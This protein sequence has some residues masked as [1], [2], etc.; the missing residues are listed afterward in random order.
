MRVTV[1]KWREGGGGVEGPGDVCVCGGGG[2]GWE[3]VQLP[4]SLMDEAVLKSA[5]PGL[6]GMAR[7]HNVGFSTI[8]E[9]NTSV[10]ILNRYH[11]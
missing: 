2:G 8:P 11:K 9:C 4:G 1:C 3:G 5:G 10:S 6:V 7:Y